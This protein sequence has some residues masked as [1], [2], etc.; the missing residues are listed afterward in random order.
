M[1]HDTEIRNAFII[2]VKNR[3][4]SLQHSDAET[5]LSVSTRYTYFEK[6]CKDSANKVI[7]LKPKLKK[8]IPCETENICQKHDILHK[9]AQMKESSPTLM[10]INKFINAQESEFNLYDSEQ[11]NYLNKNICEIL[12]AVTN[13]KSALAWETIIKS[14]IERNQINLN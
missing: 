2:T 11:T 1:K 14:A 9:A 7:P 13:K 10:K 4:L 5:T 6:A 12:K 8:R 3:F